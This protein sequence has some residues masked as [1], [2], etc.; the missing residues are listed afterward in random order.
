MLLNASLAIQF[1]RTLEYVYSEESCH[2]R[3][4][5]YPYFPY[6]DLFMPTPSC[7]NHPQA[8][9]AKPEPSGSIL[10]QLASNAFP[11][12][13]TPLV[14]R[15]MHS[16]HY[17]HSRPNP[18]LLQ[19]FLFL[20]SSQFPTSTLIP[21]PMPFDL[22]SFVSSLFPMSHWSHD[23]GWVKPDCVPPLLNVS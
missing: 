13:L 1:G 14:S 16:Q 20:A 19:P 7:Q 2:N 10:S 11:N 15:Q 12:P 9:L 17:T 21:N 23:C 4:C 6:P 22:H 18:T 8:P 3:D 5:T